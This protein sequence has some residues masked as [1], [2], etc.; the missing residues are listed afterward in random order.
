M[1]RALLR[2]LRGDERPSVCR[3]AIATDEAAG[4]GLVLTEDVQ[5]DDLL[6]RVA[7]NALVNPVSLARGQRPSLEATRAP[8]AAPTLGAT[9]TLPSRAVV[10]PPLSTHQHLA[11]LLALSRASPDRRTRISTF[12]QSLPA[13]FD[14]V[15]LT[16]ALRGRA[17]GDGS[18][19]PLL[20]ALPF[21][22]ACTADR[23]RERFERDWARVGAETPAAVAQIWA[24][25]ADPADGT[26]TDT[27]RPPLRKDAFLWAWLCVNSRCVHLDLYR[28]RH[29]D[30]FTLAP[31]LDM[32]N[33]TSVPWLE[34]K[35]QCSVRDGLELRAPAQ[36]RPEAAG[37]MG[38]RKGDP[39]CITYGAH[40][41]ATLLAE[42]GF[43][44]GREAGKAAGAPEKAV[45]PARSSPRTHA[46]RGNPFSDVLVDDL[47]HAL[48]QQQGS[49]GVWKQELLAAE[50]YWNDYTLHPVPAPAHPSHRLHAA[51]R[52]SGAPLRPAAATTPRASGV[53]SRGAGG[54]ALARRTRTR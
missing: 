6:L 40:S 9:P 47:V 27:A 34:C 18:G 49:T 53:W 42:Y 7:P 25:V 8:D 32:A 16:W 12:V 36:P 41:N 46:W 35:V 50:G 3:V 17:A 23:V 24:A 15:P 44:L 29:A 28:P 2:P 11:M 52:L 39:V 51:L 22:A 45:T 1:E 48:L 33:H 43:L 26:P 19:K 5:P 30:N 31:L 10:L 54:R 38:W 14:T 20:A 37:R 4:R 13:S 21:T